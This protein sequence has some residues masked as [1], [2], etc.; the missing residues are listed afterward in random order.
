MNEPGKRSKSRR[1]VKF[2]EIRMQKQISSWRKELP[3]IDEI[4][5]VS[6]N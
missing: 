2:W 3:I 1:N 4:G 5:T 6:D